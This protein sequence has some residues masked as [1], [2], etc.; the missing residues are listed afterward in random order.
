MLDIYINPD[1]ETQEAISRRMNIY[2]SAIEDRVSAILTRVRISG[3]EAIFDISEEI[4]G[5]RMESLK[6]SEEEYQEAEAAVSHELK[7]AIANAAM[8]IS[9]FH[10]AQRFNDVKVDT[11]P[12]VM[13]I[14]KAVPIQNVGIYVPGGTAP[15]FSTVLMLAIPAKI[16]GCKYVEMCTPT[17][18]DGKV[19]PAVLYTA[20]CCGVDA[21]YKIGGAQAIGAMAYGTQS[22]RKADKIFG[23][24]NRYVAKAKQ[25][26]QFQGVAIDMLAGPS[27]VL[28][29]ADG[30]ANPRFVAADLL[31]QA[32]HGTDSQ[33]MLACISE[34]FAKAVKA[35]VDMLLKTQSRKDIVIQSLGHSSI[36]VFDDISQ[37]IDFSNA[38]APEHLI[39]AVK[40]TWRVA[41]KITA[42][43]SVFLGNYAPESAGDYASGTNHTLPTNGTAVAAS[44]VNLDSY[45]HKI[46]FQEISKDG[47]S[48]LGKSITTMARAEGLE[49]HALAVDVRLDN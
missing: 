12:G 37:C 40:D 45:M 27:E 38:Y 28:V 49:A 33:A 32:E 47:L 9:E 43:G 2:D 36:A 17:G 23:P 1:K 16:A 15:L 5:Y 26:V 20:K 29:I 18:K 3:D 21:V 14:Q 25:I 11:T 41:D 31:S 35:E 6:V 7:T 39:L 19:A 34:D 22:V 42:A 4:D 48:R 24:G 46:T 8:N 30:T 13:C 10:K 44:G